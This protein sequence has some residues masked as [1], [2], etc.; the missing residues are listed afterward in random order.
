M[1][2]RS[3][4]QFGVLVLVLLLALTVCGC[5][6]GGEETTTTGIPVA[7]T[8]PSSPGTT[9]ADLVGKS[10]EPTED[11]P[12]EFVDAYGV[13]PIVLL[14][15]APGGT[16]DTSVSEAVDGLSSSFD[17]YLFLIYDYKTPEAYG[18]LPSLLQVGYPPELILIDREG[19]IQGIWNGYV[20]EGTMNQAL[21]NLDRM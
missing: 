10:I 5:G 2:G 8:G 12:A 21:V 20:D 1:S 15:Y 19:V 6:G 3:R 11:T 9:V 16:D 17:N 13:R 18:D 14:F 4:Q 7:T